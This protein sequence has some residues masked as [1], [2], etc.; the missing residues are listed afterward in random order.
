[1]TSGKHFPA[2]EVV[3]LSTFPAEINVGE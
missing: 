1:M 2:L 3:A